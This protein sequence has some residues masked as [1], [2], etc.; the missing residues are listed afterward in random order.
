MS[1]IRDAGDSA[2]LLEWDEVI[3]PEI[4]GQAIA[5]AA[6]LR[7]ATLP[8]VRDVV[9]TYRSVALFFDPL[10]SDLQVLREAVSRLAATPLE[11]VH[12]NTIEVPVS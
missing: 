5:V 9:P 6:A 10:K 3:H 11:V 12:G 2:L 8:G 7:N 1:R 4:N